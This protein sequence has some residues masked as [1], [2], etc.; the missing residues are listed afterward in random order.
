LG[1]K[2]RGRKK[3]QEEGEKVRGAR[4]KKSLMPLQEKKHPPGKKFEKKKPKP[5]PSF[6]G[7]KD[8]CY[9]ARRGKSPRKTKKR[10]DL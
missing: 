4:T 7:E 9:P 5:V 3:K 1:L 10:Q 6:E 2:L 8:D